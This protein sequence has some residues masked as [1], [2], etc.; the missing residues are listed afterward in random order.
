MKTNK[1]SD[2]LLSKNDDEINSLLIK[3]VDCLESTLFDKIISC[4]GMILSNNTKN[5]NIF[6]YLK[7]GIKLTQKSYEYHKNIYDLLVIILLKTITNQLSLIKI[8][9]N[10]INLTEK[11]N[12][13]TNNFTIRLI[14]YLQYYLIKIHHNKNLN[15]EKLIQTLINKLVD[16]EHQ[17]KKCCMMDVEVEYYLINMRKY[18][19]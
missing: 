15:L 12:Y 9:H 19:S 4:D 14:F 5:L 2:I 6:Y 13:T 11:I 3:N 8:I 1:I 16:L 7:Y 10:L 17:L 18:I